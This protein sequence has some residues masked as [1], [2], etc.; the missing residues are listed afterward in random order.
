MLY[1]IVRC[2]ILSYS[3]IVDSIIVYSII[4]YFITLHCTM[5][6]ILLYYIKLYYMISY[7]MVLYSSRTLKFAAEAAASRNGGQCTASAFLGRW[8]HEIQIAI[9]RRRAAM[10]RAVLPKPSTFEQWLLSGNV[11]FNDREWGR[12]E[13]LVEDDPDD[14]TGGGLAEASEDTDSLWGGRQDRGV[15]QWGTTGRLCT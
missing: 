6:Y 8:R 15:T 13:T 3:T 7:Y 10:F 14:I 5:Y 11:D 1:Y 4:L 9:L 2:A 12:L